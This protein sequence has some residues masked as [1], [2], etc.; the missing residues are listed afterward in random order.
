MD[1]TVQRGESHRGSIESLEIGVR[2]LILAE[3]LLVDEPEFDRVLHRGAMSTAIDKL[4]VAYRRVRDRREDSSTLYYQSPHEA[5]FWAYRILMAFSGQSECK[6][7]LI[8]LY[9]VKSHGRS[10]STSPYRHGLIRIATSIVEQFESGNYERLLRMQEAFLGRT[11]S[12]LVAVLAA[13]IK[14]I[15][16]QKF[17]TTVSSQ[18]APGRRVPQTTFCRMMGFDPFDR[19]AWTDAFFPGVPLTLKADSVSCPKGVEPQQTVDCRAPC[20]K[21]RRAIAD[22]PVSRQKLLDPEFD[23]QAAGLFPSLRE[24]YANDEGLREALLIPTEPE[25]RPK[26]NL[27]PARRGRKEVFTVN[28]NLPTKPPPTWSSSAFG[29]GL[30]VPSRVP[31]IF[32][33]GANSSHVTSSPWSQASQ[34]PVRPTLR[35]PVPAVMRPPAMDRA[36]PRRLAWWRRDRPRQRPRDRPL[37]RWERSPLRVSIQRRFQQPRLVFNYLRFGRLRQPHL[38]KALRALR[39]GRY[40]TKW[41]TGLFSERLYCWRASQWNARRARRLYLNRP[42]GV[43]WKAKRLRGAGR[44]PLTSPASFETCWSALELVNSVNAPNNSS[45][46]QRLPAPA[47]GTSERSGIRL[48]TTR[49]PEG[50]LP[51]PAPGTSVRSGI[52]LQ[53]ARTPEGNLPTPAPGTSVRSGIRLQTPEG[54]LP[55]PAPETSV[56]SGVRRQSRVQPDKRWQSAD[57][58]FTDDPSSFLK[59]RVPRPHQLTGALLPNEENVRSLLL[60][61]ARCLYTLFTAPLHVNQLADRNHFYAAGFKSAP[62]GSHLTEDITGPLSTKLKAM[63][64]KVH[65]SGPTRR[66]VPQCWTRFAYELNDCS[67]LQESFPIALYA[68]FLRDVVGWPVEQFPFHDSE[69]TVQTQ[70]GKVRMN[71]HVNWVAEQPNPPKANLSIVILDGLVC[72]TNLRERWQS[73]GEEQE[74]LRQQRASAAELDFAFNRSGLRCS[75]PSFTMVEDLLCSQAVLDA[76]QCYLCPENIEQIKRAVA[77]AA[78]PVMVVYALQ[79]HPVELELCPARQALRL[80]AN[81]ATTERLFRHVDALVTRAVAEVAELAKGHP[82]LTAQCLGVAQE[83][84]LRYLPTRWDMGKAWLALAS[85]EV[86]QAVCAS[87]RQVRIAYDSEVIPDMGTVIEKLFVRVSR[88]FL[89][90]AS[91]RSTH[92]VAPTTSREELATLALRETLKALSA[93]GGSEASVSLTNSWRGLNLPAPRRLPAVESLWRSLH[94]VHPKSGPPDLSGDWTSIAM[95]VNFWARHTIEVSETPP[96][97]V[98][99]PYALL[100]SPSSPL[101]RVLQQQHVE[102]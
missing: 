33:D 9:S 70:A 18:N 62:R 2:Y 81:S 64:L 73:I 37:Q 32:G 65:I 7:P 23:P 78:G 46:G 57:S 6:S 63:Q 42:R 96:I 55:S 75:E 20:Y 71:V 45:W 25:T 66:R 93:D 5:E 85:P 59:L 39:R 38:Q 24:I 95:N 19:V 48:Q 92:R 47:P 51:T 14:P 102:N 8:D 22:C 100:L 49:T 10:H 43:P 21:T 13:R 41:P 28:S 4:M 34:V 77:S 74:V 61:M 72:V 12:L 1:I 98:A 101:H 79:P 76:A 54:N 69:Q 30:L 83:D 3:E 94:S 99:G 26:P 56:R 88:L 52:R 89:S 29:P 35:P 90:N 15:A 86:H 87:G 68:A 17:L 36:A 31:P 44:P 82:A 11:Q 40:C 60:P 91:L 50:N 58:E 80:G 67:P 97:E 16:R 53:T 84:T 27:S